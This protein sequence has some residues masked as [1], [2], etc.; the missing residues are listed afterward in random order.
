MILS[1][2]GFY[3][4]QGGRFYL[5]TCALFLKFSSVLLEL[6]LCCNSIFFNWAC[7]NISTAL[8]L[9]FN[10]MHAAILSLQFCFLLF[11][12][13]PSIWAHLWLS[14][15]LISLRKFINYMWQLI[16]RRSYS[17]WFASILVKCR[18]LFMIFLVFCFWRNYIIGNCALSM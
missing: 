15:F 9:K 16:Y 18:A 17:I 7:A 2:Y 10:S 14:L 6:N 5:V 8:G 11:L 12:Y 1:I 13:F 4:P 3:T